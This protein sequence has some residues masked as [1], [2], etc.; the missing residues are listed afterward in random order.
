MA[1]DDV[2]YD[3][4]LARVEAMAGA[5]GRVWHA[6]RERL[7]GLAY[8]MLGSVA[9]AEEVVQE[10]FLRLMRTDGVADPGAW[11]TTVVSRLCLDRL[12]A[13]RTQRE[14]Y[15]GQWLP[16]PLLAQ[17]G[18]DEEVALAESVAVAMLVVLETLSPLERVVFVLHEVFGFDHPAIAALLGRSPVAVRQVASRARRHVQARRPRFE[19]DAVQRERV[20][21]AFLAACAGADLEGLVAVLDPEVVL[22]S[23]GGGK[24]PSAP[25][26][27]TGAM[28][29]ARAIVGLLRL[30]PPSVAARVAP[31]NGN[32]GMVYQY[33]PDG[34][35]FAVVSVDV[36][37]GRVIGV[38]LQ[39]NP[40]KL[41]HLRLPA[42]ADP[43]DTQ[44][45]PP[46]DPPAP[47]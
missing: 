21:R 43:A 28:R 29:V 16:E 38:N 19:V 11:L 10:G 22:R 2:A 4:A 9:D 47:P 13:A 37:G 7:V 34:R 25:H 35:L 18:P 14:V 12:A 39:A 3:E 42:T 24:V 30:V 36:A 41:E 5:A 44:P 8:R 23:D 46:A 15:V 1:S 31:V 32:L 40:D 27:I 20:A 26:P 45:L 33:Q 6:E 17:A